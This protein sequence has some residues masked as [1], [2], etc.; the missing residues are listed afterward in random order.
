MFDRMLRDVDPRV[1]EILDQALA[2]KEM[3]ETDAATLLQVEGA[4]L[5]ALLWAGVI[6]PWV[7]VQEE[8]R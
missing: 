6:K 5:H 8:D 4:N 2:G 1:A 7:L 3:S